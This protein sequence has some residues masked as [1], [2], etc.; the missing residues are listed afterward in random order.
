M[1]KNT[2]KGWTGNIPP[3]KPCVDQNSGW[4]L[5]EMHVNED[6]I[7]LKAVSRVPRQNKANYWLAW[8]RGSSVF[9]KTRDALVAA[10]YAPELL[11]WAEACVRRCYKS[12]NVIH[13]RQKSS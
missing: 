12:G 13:L 11:D 4:A 1:R 7:N 6:F 8:H 10:E 2:T 3:N 9:I 5:F